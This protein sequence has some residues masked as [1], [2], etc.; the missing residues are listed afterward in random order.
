MKLNAIKFNGFTLEKKRNRWLLREEKN[1][2]SPSD[3]KVLAALIVNKGK[4]VSWKEITDI[5]GRSEPEQSIMKI[6]KALGS[7]Y[8]KKKNACKFIKTI[9]KT[10]YQ[11]NYDEPIKFYGKGSLLLYPITASE[12][13][14]DFLTE[15]LKIQI[16]ITV[17]KELNFEVSETEDVNA[18]SED[19]SC[20]IKGKCTIKNGVYLLL[21]QISRNG[22]KSIQRIVQIKGDDIFQ[23]SSEATSKIIQKLKKIFPETVKYDEASR[24]ENFDSDLQYS[25]TDD[26]EAQKF[27]LEGEHC[28]N[29]RDQQSVLQGLDYFK[30]AIA[31]D[32]N[33]LPAWIGIAKSYVILCVQGSESLY[34]REAISYA[35]KALDKCDNHEKNFSLSN[36]LK[37]DIEA[38]KG[39]IYFVY[40]WNIS[41]SLD[42]F[43]KSLRE[44]PKNYMART[45]YA[46]C[47]VRAGDAKKA[48]AEIEKARR[49]SGYTTSVTNTAYI[50]TLYLA[51]DYEKAISKAKEILELTPNLRLG[52]LFWGAAACQMGDTETALEHFLKA[53]SLIQNSAAIGELGHV[54]GLVGKKAE[55]EELLQQLYRIRSRGNYASHYND[56]K[57]YLGLNSLDKCF[58]ELEKAYEE[59]SPWLAQLAV[60]PIF[61]SI[62]KDPRYESF[63]QKIC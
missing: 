53:F 28:W 54:Y 30:K 39:L 27:F 21:L 43:V 24:S 63:I 38:I 46:Q 25:E 11:W 61:D 5:S 36:Q 40:E 1:S 35:V 49:H 37:S 60:E 55:A 52:H 26:D 6:R 31:S 59:R 14:S 32:P 29:K 9:H 56:A 48:L 19:F 22:K 18:S 15:N 16:P 12:K 50:Q 8:I 2:L 51:R 20:S 13:E 44:T 10:G 58:E 4:I 42:S 57:I 3:A 41:K 23:L 17:E 34:P 45:W 33:F 62:R 7:I 47:L